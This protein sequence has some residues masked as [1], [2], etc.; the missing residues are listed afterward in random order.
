MFIHLQSK[1]TYNTYA[2]YRFT[3]STVT[4][5]LSSFKHHY[6]DD[7]DSDGEE[8][9]TVKGSCFLFTQEITNGNFRG[10]ICDTRYWC[11]Q[12]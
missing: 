1:N 10:G 8:D 9:G 7:E 3:H 11:L 4:Y 6:N 5:T 12:N 2:L